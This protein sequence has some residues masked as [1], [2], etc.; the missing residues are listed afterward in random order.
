M[1]EDNQMMRDQRD[2]AMPVVKTVR[3][4]SLA[5]TTTS[6]STQTPELKFK[7]F[8]AWPDAANAWICYG[9]DPVAIAALTQLS[10]ITVTWGTAEADDVFSTTITHQDGTTSTYAL[11]T[12]TEA[13]QDEVATAWAALIDAHASYSAAAVTNKITITGPTDGDSYSLVA[14]AT[15]GGGNADESVAVT[16]PCPNIPLSA[17]V[18]RD[19]GMDHD[20]KVAAITSSGTATV[21]IEEHGN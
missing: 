7:V 20:D 13:D 19:F 9:P 12:T 5:A 1:S 15:D 10:T 4:R 2:A 16:Q 14:T 18:I 8:S 17:N 11:T 21:Y 3:V 6:G